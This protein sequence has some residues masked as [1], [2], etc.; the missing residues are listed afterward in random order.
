[1]WT[2]TGFAGLPAVV[3][4][5][6][7][8]FSQYKPVI[9]NLLH[10]MARV[11][12]LLKFHN[13][14]KNTVFTNVTKN[15]CNFDLFTS[16]GYRCVVCFHFFSLDSLRERRSVPPTAQSGIARFKTPCGTLAETHWRE[17]PPAS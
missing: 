14:L 5:S 13:T 11:N 1:M 12:E 15:R 6:E 3:I 17:L 16:N 4:L 9:F 2:R 8:Y 10:L 7:T